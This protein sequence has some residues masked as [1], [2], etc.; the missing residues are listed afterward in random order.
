MTWRCAAHQPR[1]A[2]FH[3]RFHPLLCRSFGFSFCSLFFSFVCFV[4]S[5]LY[6][7]CQRNFASASF[8]LLFAPFLPGRA[9]ISISISAAFSNFHTLPHFSAITFRDAARSPPLHPFTFPPSDFAVA[10][11]YAEFLPRPR[12]SFTIVT[13]YYREP[14]G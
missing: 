12:R 13:V 6:L 10:S 8:P 14:V 9:D 1:F 5:T 4:I 2:P 7:L 11:D 3:L